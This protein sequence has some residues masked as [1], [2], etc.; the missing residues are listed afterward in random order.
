LDYRDWDTGFKG[1]ETY[2]DDV[3]KAPY[4]YDHNRHLFATFDDERSIAL[5]ARY[6]MDQQLEGIMFWELSLDKEK[7][8]MLD[9]IIAEKN[10]KR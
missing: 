3:A 10:S 9:A 1:F 4:R 8:G 6:A 5:K 2:W 7:Q